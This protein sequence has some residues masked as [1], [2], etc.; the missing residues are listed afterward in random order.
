MERKYRKWGSFALWFLGQVLFC[1]IE[2]TRNRT[3]AFLHPQYPRY[4]NVHYEN[5]SWEN[6]TLPEILTDKFRDRQEVRGQHAVLLCT[7]D[8][9]KRY[10]IEKRE[11]NLTSDTLARSARKFILER[12]THHSYLCTTETHQKKR[13]SDPWNKTP[14]A[15]YSSNCE[16]DGCASDE[17]ETQRCLILTTKASVS[18]SLTLQSNRV[19]RRYSSACGV[20]KCSTSRTRAFRSELD[21]AK[22]CS[23]HNYG[24]FHHFSSRDGIGVIRVASCQYTNSETQ[25]CFVKGSLFRHLEG[26]TW[27]F[28]VA[29]GG[30]REPLWSSGSDEWF[31]GRIETKYLKKLGDKSFKFYW[32]ALSIF[33]DQLYRK[34]A[35]VTSVFFVSGNGCL[36]QHSNYHLIAIA[37][38]VVAPVC[39]SQTEMEAPAQP[40]VP[41]EKPYISTTDLKYNKSVWNKRKWVHWELTPVR[42]TLKG[43]LPN[44]VADIESISCGLLL[45]FA[46]LGILKWKDFSNGNTLCCNDMFL[47][48]L[49]LYRISRKHSSI[50]RLPSRHQR[51]QSPLI[52]WTIGAGC[53][54]S[55]CFLSLACND[56][57]R[58][59]LAAEYSCLEYDSS[60]KMF[61][62]NCSL[63]WTN[64]SDCI[65]LQKNEIFEGNGHSVHLT[66]VS[67]WEGLIRIDDDFASSPSSLQD[68]PVI[69]NVHMIGGETSDKGGFIV[70]PEQKHFIVQACSST[71]VIH[72]GC[73]DGCTG[74]GGICGHGCSGDILIEGCFSSG[75]MQRYSG[76]IA[77]SHLGVGGGRGNVTIVQCH[78]K[79][80]ING[81]N[82]GGICGIRTGEQNG[83]CVL[84]THS[85][86]R[87]NIIGTGS[88]GICGEGAGTSNGRVNIEQCYSRGEIKGSKSGGITG[89]GTAW[90]DGKVSIVNCYS[91]GNIQG[92]SGGIC[93]F[94]TGGERGTVILSNV[95]ASGTIDHDDAGGLIQHIQGNALA[96]YI[97][98]SVYNGTS[99][100]MTGQN[101]ANGDVVT[102]SKN[103]GKLSDITG[104]A[105][106]YEENNC[107]DTETIW[108]VV[109]D[110][111]PVLLPRPSAIPEPSRT[112]AQTPSKSPTKTLSPTRTSTSSRSETRTQTETN[113]PSAMP[114]STSTLTQSGATTSSP[115]ETRSATKTRTN[116]ATSSS[117]WTLTSTQSGT[118]SPYRTLTA[119]ANQSSSES[120]SLTPTATETSW[121]TATGTPTGLITN[122]QSPSP[123]CSR[124]STVSSSNTP[125]TSPMPSQMKTL[126]S[127]VTPSPSSFWTRSPT[128]SSS[129]S[130]RSFSAIAT[131]STHA[132]FAS[133][134]T[135]V[136]LP[137]TQFLSATPSDK[138]KAPS[139]LS[140]TAVFLSP[141][142]SASDLYSSSEAPTSY[143][144]ASPTWCCPHSGESRLKAIS[145]RPDVM[146]G[147]CLLAIVCMMVLYVGYKRLRNKRAHVA[148]GERSEAEWYAI[149]LGMG[150]VHTKPERNGKAYAPSC[151]SRG[152]GDMEPT[153]AES[154]LGNP[155]VRIQRVQ[156]IQEGHLDYE[157]N[158]A[159]EN[160]AFN[161]GLNTTSSLPF[162]L[163]DMKHIK[164]SNLS[165]VKILSAKQ[166]DLKSL[167]KT[168]TSSKIE[169]KLQIARIN[170]IDT[171][172]MSTI[173][174][175]IIKLRQWKAKLL[176]ELPPVVAISVP[177]DAQHDTGNTD[178]EQGDSSSN[179]LLSQLE[180][181]ANRRECDRSVVNDEISRYTKSRR[182]GRGVQKKEFTAIPPAFLETA[183]QK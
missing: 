68:A 137:P 128:I 149:Q 14:L 29:M 32:G 5:F 35:Q 47:W 81:V 163:V 27:Q 24:D 162:T 170:D 182:W 70:Q 110:A 129:S 3:Y 127:T 95:Y 92:S 88:G 58:H 80:D 107:W 173:D 66:E 72:G 102:K 30:F 176:S 141:T 183:E 28:T 8:D 115:S 153:A 4:L 145:E 43:F 106:C 1:E 41:E 17:A 181:A 160:G 126:S 22:S 40:F 109:P 34:R 2:F 16:R 44:C 64:S 51:K 100:N 179:K 9:N 119:S 146:V 87:G 101:D 98:M 21:D 140:S 63:T 33:V 15:G 175:T 97:G 76:G 168:D 42:D 55:M 121:V 7:A 91:R 78:S 171:T 48:I 38:W 79:G 132:L 77:G 135:I 167:G 104:T 10:I 62:L 177:E 12:N 144:T 111:F 54:I 165:K 89:R 136:S 73:V 180:F 138:S 164:P 69:R 122:N 86:S 96:I 57:G 142:A 139:S 82:S 108:H 116:S 25:K 84:I 124:R 99:G 112:T 85:Y 31:T 118:C 134:S 36:L 130:K 158:S 60:Q 159:A 18:G 56:I 172:Q 155:L 59:A 148:K 11:S 45:G 169:R 166:P 50:S 103:S 46:L 133:G 151:N 152:Q 174:R 150:T 94:D 123:S 105:Y 147:F 83:Q 37:N 67:N 49:G 6:A 26:L 156:L 71:G 52:F 23:K 143:V 178:N 161:P 20:L 157:G 117:S 74:G 113:A 114:T 61:E 90:N 39:S 120:R 19:T 93:G 125:S 65:V 75:R 131:G 53:A 13:T 154:V